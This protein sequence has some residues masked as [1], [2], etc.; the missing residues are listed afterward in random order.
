M[1]K[2]FYYLK[3]HIN[4]FLFTIYPHQHLQLYLFSIIIFFVSI[5]IF[6]YGFFSIFLYYSLNYFNY[7]ILS[8]YLPFTHLEAHLHSQMQRNSI[9]NLCVCHFTILHPIEQKHK[10]DYYTHIS[11]LSSAKMLDNELIVFTY[12]LQTFALY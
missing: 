8:I 10:V 5:S 1:N 3:L 4:L 7:S 6:C 12:K 11:N 2:L 9:A